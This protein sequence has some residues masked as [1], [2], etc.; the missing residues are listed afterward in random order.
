[1]LGALLTGLVAGILAR[2]LIP[3]MWSELSGPASWLFSLVLGL[4]GA[5]LPATNPVSSAPSTCHMLG[6]ARVSGPRP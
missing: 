1:M 6:G 4:A 5:M 2:L 3:D